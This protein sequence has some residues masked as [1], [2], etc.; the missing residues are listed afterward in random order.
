MNVKKRSVGAVL[1][2]SIFTC[3]IYYIYLIYKLGEELNEVS[4]SNS[5][6]GV[7]DVLLTFFT[8]GLYGI[9]WHYKIARQIEDMEYNLGM[10]V[11]SI[12]IICLILAV[13]MLPLISM[14]INQSELNHVLDEVTY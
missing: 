11:G 5:N 10:R 3:G 2:L 1:C 13:L 7:I 14:A 12:S 8:C 6:N 4:C 9:Y